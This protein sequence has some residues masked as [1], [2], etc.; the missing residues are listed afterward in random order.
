ML[1]AMQWLWVCVLYIE[2]FFASPI[3]KIIKPDTAPN[4][5][6]PLPEGTVSGFTLPEP[7]L[8]VIAVIGGIALVVG[9]IYVVGKTYIPNVERAAKTVVQKAATLTVDRAV[10]HH[11]VPEKKRRMAA[12]RTIFWLKICISALP[13]L[14]VFVFQESSTYIPYDVAK[15]GI[16]I[17]TLLAIGGVCLQHVFIHRWRLTKEA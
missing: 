3:G 14:V 1:W 13:T 16:L 4:E 10:K 5:P 11:I 8:V 17:A 12:V 2:Q 7:V 6:V 15:A 9:A